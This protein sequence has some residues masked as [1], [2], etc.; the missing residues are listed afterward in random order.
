MAVG[1]AVLA[2]PGLGDQ[3]SLA[4]PPGEQGLSDDVVELVRAGVGQV[5]ALEQH[6]DPEL[7][8]EPPALGDRSR[9]A[10]VVAQDPVELGPEGGSAQAS[11]NA[12]LQLLA[13]RHQR[14]GDEP[15][16]EVAEPAVRSRPPHE[17]VAGT[18][19]P[20]GSRRGVGDA[21]DRRHRS[22]QS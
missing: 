7:L 6:P 2:G 1:H 20:S 4:H 13:G 14:L 3:P 22:I 15:A 17:R 18:V 16:P 10:P 12:A 11:A 5:L 19:R 9:P 21:P 8:G